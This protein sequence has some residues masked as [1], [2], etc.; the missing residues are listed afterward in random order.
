VA[1]ERRE[2]GLED[3]VAR[4]LRLSGDTSRGLRYWDGRMIS[5]PRRLVGDPDWSAG[6]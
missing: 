4:S 1:A 5:Q 2:A 6:H 3:E